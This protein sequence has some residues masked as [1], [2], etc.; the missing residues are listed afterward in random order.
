[1]NVQLRFLFSSEFSGGLDGFTLSIEMFRYAIGAGF[2]YGPFPISGND[3]L[4][5]AT[6][7]RRA[8]YA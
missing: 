3:V 2:A 6:H 4:C 5:L 7:H 1:M 8:Y